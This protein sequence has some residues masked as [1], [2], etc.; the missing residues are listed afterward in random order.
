ML[1]VM[2]CSFEKYCCAVVLH[3]RLSTKKL[4][5]TLKE[6]TVSICLN[7]A[8][9]RDVLRSCSCIGFLSEQAQKRTSISKIPTESITITSAFP[10]APIHVL[11]VSEYP[12]SRES[13]KRS[14]RVSEMVCAVGGVSS[15]CGVSLGV[16]RVSA[17]SNLS[18]GGMGFMASLKLSA[19]DATLAA[20]APYI[21]C[22][23]K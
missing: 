16:G 8:G 1:L 9:N 3:S 13:S 22:E 19:A 5:R 4:S 21:I 20:C 18:S 2:L 10:D 11:R 15:R 14:K 12:E 17:S 23:P 6:K 7:V